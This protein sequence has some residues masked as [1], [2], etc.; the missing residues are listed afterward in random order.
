MCQATS[1]T[2]SSASVQANLFYQLL[3]GQIAQYAAVTDKLEEFYLVQALQH[4]DVLE[5]F[6]SFGA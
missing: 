4:G 2:T 1:K 5:N 6:V 3:D